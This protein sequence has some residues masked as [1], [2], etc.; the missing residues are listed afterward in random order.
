M[1]LWVFPKP[2][3]GAVKVIFP[4]RFGAGEA[5]GADFQGAW[6]PS[7]QPTLKPGADIPRTGL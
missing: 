6:A 2:K 4:F 3:G 1:S 7:T 5:V